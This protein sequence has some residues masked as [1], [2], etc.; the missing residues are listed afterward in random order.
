MICFPF[1]VISLCTHFQSTLQG[2][3]VE[4]NAVRLFFNV[5]PKAGQA[6]K[7]RSLNLPDDQLMQLNEFTEVVLKANHFYQFLFF[8]SWFLIAN[9]NL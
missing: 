1:R 6:V 3:V 7:Q 8:K 5:T 9:P 2:F 4:T